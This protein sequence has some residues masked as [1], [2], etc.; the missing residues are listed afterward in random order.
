MSTV[1]VEDRAVV[2]AAIRLLLERTQLIAFQY[3]S[4]FTIHFQRDLSENSSLPVQM[5]L[6]LRAHWSPAATDEIPPGLVVNQPELLHCKAEQ[7]YQAF[8]IMSFVGHSVDHVDVGD[9]SSLTVLLSSG[10]M[11]RVAG[12][13]EEWDF[14]W[15]LFVPSD[16]LGVD[17]W[18]INCD[19]AG[20]IDATWPGEAP[21]PTKVE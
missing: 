13:E 18:S 15:Y 16:N 14:S 7:P 3:D 5:S 11:I 19:A 1:H 12:R 9:D 2:T 17:K 20:F 8:R 6:V 21:L 4:G 10:N